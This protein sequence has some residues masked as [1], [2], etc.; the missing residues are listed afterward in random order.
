MNSVFVLITSWGSRKERFDARQ[1]KNE[2]SMIMTISF[3]VFLLW[4]P[5]ALGRIRHLRN[6]KETGVK[7]CQ[8]QLSRLF[9]LVQ[10]CQMLA[11]FSG[12]EL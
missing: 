1:D 6:E 10:F 11:I 8:T 3:F 12:V 9:H 7:M 4:Y 2:S 5:L